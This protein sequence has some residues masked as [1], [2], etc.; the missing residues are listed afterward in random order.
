MLIDIDA[1]K[2]KPKNLMVNNTARQQQYQIKTERYN[3][4]REHGS[5]LR[6]SRQRYNNGRTVRKI[7]VQESIEKCQNCQGLA[8][9]QYPYS[10]GMY[11][12]VKPSLESNLVMLQCGDTV[13]IKCIDQHNKNQIGSS[14]Q[15]KR[16]V[17]TK[18][19]RVIV[20]CPVC[21]EVQPIPQK[22]RNNI[23]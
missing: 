8:S 20:K 19:D 15:K 2:S 17:Q 4:E 16:S 5:R 21:F 7:Q 18:D 12:N 10:Y 11:Q 9:A 22:L 1:V 6:Q 23:I 13:C 3:T 14:S